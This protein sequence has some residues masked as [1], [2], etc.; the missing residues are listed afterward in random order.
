MKSGSLLALGPTQD[1]VM[2][3]ALKQIY[4][5]DVVVAYI[6]AADRRICVPALN[7]EPKGATNE[8]QRT[9]YSQGHDR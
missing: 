7:V 6:D 4:G 8:D 9:Q 2:P 3:D 1:V 5:V